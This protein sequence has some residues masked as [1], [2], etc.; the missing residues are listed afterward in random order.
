MQTEIEVK[1]L[2]VDH[3]AVRAKL[4]SLGASCEQPMRLMKRAII[5]YADRRLQTTQNG[6]VRVRDEGDKITL[7]YKESNETTV[8][9]AREIEL[10]IDSYGQAIELFKA[11]GLAV[12][13]EQETKRETWVLD[14][15]KVELDEWP[16]LRP[17]FEI[18]GPDEATIRGVADKLG[19]D[20][21]KAVFG[22]TTV[23]YKL[24]Y[25]GIKDN[26]TVSMINPG[27]YFDQP[28]PQWLL[29]RQ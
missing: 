28:T 14:G 27:M 3:D 8:D 18:E 20:W 5:D 4:D 19:Y 23:A 1:F 6:W 29:D 10:I 9:G 7:T 16:W 24:Q 21:S 15:C 11:I 22:S 13:S 17:Y 12:E 26:E 2:D 25:P